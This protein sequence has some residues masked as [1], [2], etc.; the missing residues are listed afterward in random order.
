M[1]KRKVGHAQNSKLNG[2]WGKHVRKFWKKL[3]SRKRRLRDRQIIREEIS[4]N[5]EM[6][7]DL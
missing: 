6:K 4:L 5:E 2:E 3:T 7:K 1:S